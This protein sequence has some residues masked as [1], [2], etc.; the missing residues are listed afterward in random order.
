MDDDG[1]YGDGQV[2]AAEF[3]MKK[4]EKKGGKLEYLV[5]WKGWAHKYS[6]WEP[7]VN[8]IDRRL[9]HQFERRL[10]LEPP[11]PKRGRKPKS[12]AAA[13]TPK[14]NNNEEVE[15]EVGRWFIVFIIKH[16]SRLISVD[17]SQVNFIIS[18]IF[19]GRFRQGQKEEENFAHGAVHAADPLG[20]DTEAAGQI[21]GGRHE[22][23]HE[24]LKERE[25]C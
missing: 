25:G 17:K 20:Q 10:A 4:R 22:R 1:G 18:Y 15:H 8:I 12:S 14:N 9:I 21:P 3:I 6:T 7:E 5:K 16:L 11:P 2:Y 13:T 24:R 19:A 23:G